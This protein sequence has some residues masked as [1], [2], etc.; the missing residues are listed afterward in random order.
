MVEDEGKASSS[1]DKR[2]KHTSLWG[3]PAILKRPLIMNVVNVEDS[4]IARKIAMCT[5]KTKEGKR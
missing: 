5:K 2:K 1:G 3:H 4:D